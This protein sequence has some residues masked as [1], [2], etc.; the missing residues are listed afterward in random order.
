MKNHDL[1][2]YL[3]NKVGIILDESAKIKNP[4]SK[5]Q[6]FHVSDRFKKCIM[7]GTPSA[8]RPYDLWSQI[9]DLDNRKALGDNFELFKKEFDLKTES[10]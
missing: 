3:E 4:L 9:K 7:T 5:F 1:K 8:N 6:N 2:N 10:K